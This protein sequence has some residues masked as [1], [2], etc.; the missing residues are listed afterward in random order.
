MP[1]PASR[2]RWITGAMLGL[3]MSIAVPLGGVAHATA[4]SQ[5]L[6]GRVESNGTPLPGYV[7]TLYRTTSGAPATLRDA[8]SNRDGRFTISYHPQG[9][10]NSVFYLIAR[11]GP[12]TLV[13][14]LGLQASPAFAN[15]PDALV[16][17]AETAPSTASPR[18]LADRVVINERTTVATG[19]SLAQFINGPRISG[20]RVGVRNAAAMVGN[21]VDVT[22][23]EIAPVL[24]HRPNGSATST[25]ATFNSLANMV[26]AC[27]AS[28]PDCVRLFVAAPW[29]DGNK[30]GHTLLER[31]DHQCLRR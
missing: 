10:R 24:A 16:A 15:P 26:A 27:V 9:D 3:L 29:S 8:T 6:T 30:T 23:G 14:V 4:A 19:Y 21:M 13:T 31:S 5:T 7:V 11:K 28:R 20:N 22:T 17:D 2:W 18:G 12:V 1:T 25:L